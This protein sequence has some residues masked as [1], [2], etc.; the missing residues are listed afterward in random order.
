MKSNQTM[1]KYN[2]RIKNRRWPVMLLGA[3]IGLVLLS[4]VAVVVVRHTYHQNLKPISNVQTVHLITVPDGS[5]V[6]SIASLLKSQGLIRS[7]WAFQWYVS[8]KE[9]R[10]KL[11]AGTYA[12]TPSQSV[13]EIV[14]IMTQGRVAT[15]LV[16]IPPGRRIDQVR[17]ILINNGF[18]AADVDKALNSNLYRNHPALVELPKDITSLEGY[19]YP[20]SIQKDA[21]TA[22]QDLITK[23]LDEMQERLTP[24]L[25]AAFAQEGLSVYDSIKLASMVEMEVSRPADRPVVAQV[26]LSRLHQNMLLGSDVTAFYGA[27]LAGQAPSVT[28]DSPYNTRLHAGLPPTPIS[29]V[30]NSSLQAVAHPAN[31]DFLYFVAG[32]D[33]NTYFAHTAEE[34]QANVQAHCKKLCNT[35]Q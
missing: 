33:G 24:D 16:T 27:I 18:V 5:S 17:S 6:S 10:E 23:Y 28:Y 9:V 35:S 8:S 29:N 3:V 31:T 13:Q 19:I 2:L 25:R 26:F 30:S 21:A 14:G 34:H 7:D 11:Q 1:A 32:D 20:E 22:P 15:A 4:I 12:L